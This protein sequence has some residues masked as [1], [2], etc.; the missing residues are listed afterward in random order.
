MKFLFVAS[1]ETSDVRLIIF[2]FLLLKFLFVHFSN[3]L[4]KFKKNLFST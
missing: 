4:F 2:A 3:A 1:C